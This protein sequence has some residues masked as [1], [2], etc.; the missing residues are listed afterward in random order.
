MVKSIEDRIIIELTKTHRGGKGSYTFTGRPQGKE[1]REELGLSKIDLD[2]RKYQITIPNETISFNPSFYLGLFF[3]SVKN[4]K[5]FDAF[6][7]KYEIVLLED[8]SELEE[9]LLED[10]DECERQSKNEFKGKTG[11]D[12]L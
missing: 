9:L 6:K 4:L 11:I 10:F 1:V 7:E 12:L 3:L 8:E 2:E 5:G